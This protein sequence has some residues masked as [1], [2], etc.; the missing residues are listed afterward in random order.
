M[1]FDSVG[2]WWEDAAAI[3]I[4]KA[5]K[6]KRLPP[7]PVWLKPDYL[8]NLAEA[9]ACRF[10]LLSNRE[11]KESALRR[12]MFSMDIESY[13]NYMLVGFRRLSDKKIV[14]FQQIELN[15]EIVCELDLPK[16]RWCLEHLQFVTFKGNSFDVPWCQIA[17]LGH[18]AE[19][20]HEITQKLIMNRDNPGF[21]PFY[22]IVKAHK[23]V[24]LKCDHID[25][26]EVAPGTM[27]SLKTYAGRFHA[28]RLQDLP[29]HPMALLSLDQMCIIR[30]YWNN[31]LDLTEG[32]FKEL[33]SEINE[34]IELGKNFDLDLR[35]KSD[36]QIAE[37]I[38]GKLCA[39]DKRLD[40]LPKATVRPGMTFKYNPPSFIKFRSKELKQVLADLATA[41]FEID[42][43]GYVIA[44]IALEGPPKI[45]KTDK[46][47]RLVTINKTNYRMGIGGLHSEDEHMHFVSGHG[48]QLHDWDVTGYY[49]NLMINA[50]LY[51]ESCG[52]SFVIHFNHIKVERE[53]AKAAGNKKKAQTYKIITNG[54]FGKTGSPYS[55]FYAP[56]LMIQ[57]TVTG[58][59]M[60]L[61]LVERMEWA[62][63]PVVSGNTDGIV[64]K[65]PDGRDADMRAIIAQWEKDTSFQMEET[66]YKAIYSSDVNTYIAIYEKEKDGEWA[67]TK[68][69]LGQTGLMK[70][71]TGQIVA[72][73]AVAK[74][75]HGK[76][77]EETIRGCT[78]VRKFIHLRNVKGG[79]VKDGVYLGKVVRW[80]IAANESGEIIYAKSGNKVA[81]SDMAKP[82]M[83]LPESLPSDIN[84]DWYIQ[85]CENVL[86]AV[87]YN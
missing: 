19:F 62:G 63:I 69:R 76:P 50:G 81:K 2:L 14:Y 52:P 60:L 16:M 58:Q 68:G 1:R 83:V 56:E 4:P 8:P 15:G 66:R 30:W 57:T 17:L 6:Q 34:R 59:L 7:D 9:R 22:K 87:G 84:Y 36:A 33:E 71:P 85:E 35:S 86:T 45:K 79:G 21:I 75:V 47:G 31:D 38:L 53:V 61:M 13:P 39:S 46:R 64:I 49:P 41:N 48:Y 43:N 29:F 5:P 12:D 73:A 67:K 78:D 11:L 42:A 72:D 74:L 32:L 26:I 24:K 18:G 54:T 82:L 70:N 10:D 40:Y 44:P 28:G 23:G 37:A 25:L 55:I 27:D 51:P 20:M 65:C 80:Y 3:K 77:I